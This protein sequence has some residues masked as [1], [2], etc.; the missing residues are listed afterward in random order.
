MIIDDNFL[1]E[2]SINFINEIVLSEKFPFCLQKSTVNGDDQG[3]FLSH[4][5]VLRPEA[6]DGV[7]KVVS[8]YNKEFFK[9]FELFTNKHNI[10]HS[11]M[12]RCS[13]NLTFPTGNIA[14]PIH[15][16][17]NFEHKQLLVYLND[18]A[19]KE[20][21]TVI[22]DEDKVKITNEISPKQYRGI[23]FDSSPHFQYFPKKG[24][25]IVLVYTFI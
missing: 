8:E 19:D 3:G 24:I 14:C 17:H 16:D 2:E 22:L 21:K 10:D 6:C 11:Q 23:C 15:R 1:N 25:R 5:V 13:V 4:G 12:Y 9:I 20:S 18:C 7:S